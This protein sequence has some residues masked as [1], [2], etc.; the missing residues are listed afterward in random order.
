MG[1]RRTR[2]GLLG[3][4][5]LACVSAPLGVRAEAPLRAA[6]WL[7]P[8]AD[9]VT[10]LTLQPAECLAL[11]E[12]PDAA[13]S[14]EIGRAAFR[15]PLLLGGQGA[16]AGL[17]CQSCH[18]NGHGNPDFHFPGLSG[19][20]GTADVTSSVMSEVREDGAF[21]PK[22]IPTLTL[23]DSA[24][25]I[26]TRDPETGALELFIH[27]LIVEEF[28]GHEPPPAALAGLANYVRALSPAICPAEM[29]TPVTLAAD[30]ADARRA[31]R[32]A[33]SVL[34]T[35]DGDTGA[36]MLAAVRSKLEEI[37]ER[38]ADEQLADQRAALRATAA[39]LGEIR[40][41]AQDDPASAHAALETW[42]ARLTAL[43]AAL[44]SGE[45][46]SLY[47]PETLDAALSR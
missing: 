40:R 30:M 21:N 27:G 18:I 17:S 46:R 6:Q 12:N 3:A 20:P 41:T 19:A 16:R 4:A 23:S 39:L 5:F 14:V 2:L 1:R 47:D 45:P 31:L 11:P 32:T 15:T 28:A 44:A 38:F 34:E 13:L 36:L 9:A 29:D 8:E 42:P 35:G 43:E 25:P 26:V 33:Q 10:A 24:A 22:P 37:D 7:A